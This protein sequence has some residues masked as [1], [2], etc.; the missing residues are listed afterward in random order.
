MPK[1]PILNHKE[2]IKILEQ[3]GFVFERQRGSHK[4]FKKEATGITIPCHDNKDLKRGTLRNILRQ[5]DISVEELI[6]LLE[7]GK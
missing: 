4:I 2:I 5:A 3:V 7:N 1:L 6:G